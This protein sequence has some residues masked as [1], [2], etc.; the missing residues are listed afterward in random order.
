ML[1]LTVFAAVGLESPPLSL[2]IGPGACFG[3]RALLITGH[4][5]ASSLTVADALLREGASVELLVP[6]PRAGSAVESEGALRL[7]QR[8]QRQGFRQ[9]ME[10]LD[11]VACGEMMPHA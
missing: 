1:L 11:Y 9:L 6:L 8:I 7:L 4:E 2:A 5:A 10:R 3:K